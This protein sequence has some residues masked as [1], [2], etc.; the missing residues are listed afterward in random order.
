[1]I[2]LISVGIE[3]LAKKIK[4]VVR[5][6]WPEDQIKFPLLNVLCFYVDTQAPKG[7]EMFVRIDSQ[8]ALKT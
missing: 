8:V 1:M 2:A 4:C 6:K 7:C 5:G 3:H